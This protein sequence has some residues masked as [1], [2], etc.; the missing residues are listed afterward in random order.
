M[1]APCEGRSGGFDEG[2]EGFDD[3]LGGLEDGLGGLED[4]LLGGGGLDGNEEMIG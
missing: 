1:R 3:G 4:V 2:P